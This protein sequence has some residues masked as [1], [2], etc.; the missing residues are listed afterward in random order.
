MDP[1]QLALMKYWRLEKSILQLL[2]Q[3]VTT[4]CSEF[5]TSVCFGAVN[6]TAHLFDPRLCSVT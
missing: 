2:T 3:S 4:C 5:S 6:L 1:E